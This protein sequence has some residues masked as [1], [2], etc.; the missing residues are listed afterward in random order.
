M[1]AK[2]YV[3]ETCLTIP[4]RKSCADSLRQSGHRDLVEMI[5]DRETGRMKRVRLCDHEKSGRG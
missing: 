5:K 4:P 1:D 2:L 3:V